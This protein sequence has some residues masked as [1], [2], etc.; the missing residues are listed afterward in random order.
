[1]SFYEGRPLVL[2]HRGAREIAPENTLASFRAAK[3]LGADGIELD[4]MLSADGVPVVIHDSTVDRTTNGHGRVSEMTLAQLQALDAGGYKGPPFAGEPIP[5]LE[6]VLDACSSLRIN[7]ELKSHT[8]RNDGL[9]AAVAA[10]VRA[11]QLGPNIVISSFNPLSLWRMRRIAPDLRRAL[12]YSSDLPIY[13]RRAWSA[14][15]LGL[16]AVHPHFSLVNEAYMRWARQKGYHVN[17]WTVNDPAE[18]ARLLDLGV[19]ALI[20]DR[21]EVAREM[22]DVYRQRTR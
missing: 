7:I 8:T 9:E 13:L 18:M 15:L 16:D 11:R 19:D 22:V 5:T 21:P 10:L 17:V 14:P 1:M 12:L 20:T 3:E 2:G 6:A 4:V